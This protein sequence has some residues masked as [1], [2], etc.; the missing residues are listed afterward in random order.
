MGA[1]FAPCAAT[2]AP[3]FYLHAGPVE[4]KKIDPPSRQIA[5]IMAVKY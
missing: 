4:Y 1:E 5:V 2:L 3:F